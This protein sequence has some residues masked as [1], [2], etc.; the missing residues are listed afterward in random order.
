MFPLSLAHHC[1]S[2]TLFQ[3]SQLFFKLKVPEATRNYNPTETGGGAWNNLWWV[4][5]KLSCQ[6]YFYSDVFGWTNIITSYLYRIKF[7]IIR[8]VNNSENKVS[9]PSRIWSD[10]A[11]FWPDIVHWLA[12]QAIQWPF[13]V[14]L[15]KHSGR[16]RRGPQP[17]FLDQTEAQRAKKYIF[18]TSPPHLI[19]GSGWLPP[20]RPLSEDLDLPLKQDRVWPWLWK[21]TLLHSLRKGTQVVKHGKK[22][23][24]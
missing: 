9:S 10:K 2:K 14:D 6:T 16:S 22:G 17:P 5:V 19:S 8:S 15:N 13:N 21:P 12:I 7:P 24:V 3:K 11:Y 4:P 18:E 23:C 1:T 20:P